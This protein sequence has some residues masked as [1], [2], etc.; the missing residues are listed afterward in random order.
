MSDLTPEQMFAKSSLT[1]TEDWLKQLAWAQ[2]NMWGYPTS[3]AQWLL[4]HAHRWQYSPRPKHLKQR[5][6]KRCYHNS[7]ELV[8][9]GK[10]RYVYC[11]GYAT[12]MIPVEHAWVYDRTKG[13]IIDPTWNEG[14]D[15]VGVPIKRS[16]AYTQLKQGRVCLFDFEGRYPILTGEVPVEVWREELL[17]K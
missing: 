4:D 1:P 14:H 6:A 16:Y 5:P 15:Y 9:R 2:M 11:E 17:Y 3:H 13:C 7:L 10:G 12:H 8:A